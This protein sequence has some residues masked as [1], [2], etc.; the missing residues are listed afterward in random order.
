MTDARIKQV[1]SWTCRV[2]LSRPIVMGEIR[3]EYREYIVV[4]IV[5]QDGVSGIGY[6]MTRN[7]PVQAI[8]ERTLR[9][10]L[11][12]RD[13]TMT[14]Q[15]WERLYYTN[16]PMGQRGVF[17]RALS[18]I[19]IALWDL[20][21]K[22]AGMPLW[23]LLGGFRDRVPALVAGGY[24]AANVTPADLEREV[25]DYVAQGYRAI[26]I[27]AGDLEEDTARLE[28]ARSGAGK[29][30]LAY[31]AH[32][33]WR[34][35]ADVLPVVRTW[36]RFE[37][38]WIEDP[39]PSE[40][41]DAVAR[42]AADCPIPLALGED[43]MGRWTFHEI[44]RRGHADYLRIDATAMGGISEAVRVCALAS[45]YGIQ[46]SPHIF[47][48][49]HV[50]LGAAFPGVLYVEMTEPRYEVDLMYRLLTRR[51]EL[52]DGQVDAPKQPGLGIE[53]DRTAVEKYA[54]RAEE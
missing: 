19:D 49:V 34:S 9:P 38:M 42:F 30:R 33:A 32:W 14:E 50:H 45:A 35:A 5:T 47:A 3:F 18:A 16:L 10:L 12:G 53:L 52:R 54:V 13:A 46:V 41:V 2:P 4:E 48:E 29:S 1:R 7:G 26:K 25:A 28:A 22:L 39:F 31:D 24:A 40:M 44:L 51:L 43:G 23:N 27:A 11:I 6:G 36:D 17:M 8:V 21:A 15:L 20:K 37:L